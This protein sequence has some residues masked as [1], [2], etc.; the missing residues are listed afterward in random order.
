MSPTLYCYPSHHCYSNN[1][2]SKIDFFCCF[3]LFI[4]LFFVVVFFVF[5]F[6]LIK[7]EIIVKS[8]EKSEM[9]NGLD[10]A[11]NDMALFRFSKKEVKNCQYLKI[12]INV[13]QVYQ[14]DYVI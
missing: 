6:L 14:S 3:L 7:E 12:P 8:F 9:R 10:G 1:P 5:Y 13:N 11:G 4:Y 2:K